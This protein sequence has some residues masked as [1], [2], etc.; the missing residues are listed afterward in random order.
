M[1]Q[2]VGQQ[3]GHHGQDPVLV[4]ARGQ[5]FGSVDQEPLAAQVRHAGKART[6]LANERGH[7]HLVQREAHPAAVQ[8]RDGQR[9]LDAFEQ[10]VRVRADAL[11]VLTPT[12][13]EVLVAE[14]PGREPEH[15]RQRR[16]ELVANPGQQLASL[17]VQRVRP[18][19]QRTDVEIAS[20]LRVT[21]PRA[22][23]L[24]NWELPPSAS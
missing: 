21:R 1:L 23:A 4:D 17:F 10:H 19:R 22:S 3:V 5:G 2:R 16:L 15:D 11:D 9:V 8:A 7:V 20:R 6:A 12:A 18:R 13:G 14:Q 24:C